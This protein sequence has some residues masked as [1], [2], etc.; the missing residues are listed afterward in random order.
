MIFISKNR[1]RGLRST[2]DSTNGQPESLRIRTPG[3]A[4]ATGRHG[5]PIASVNSTPAA[6]IVATLLSP[7]AAWLTESDALTGPVLVDELDASVFDRSADF[8]ACALAATELAFSGFQS[9]DRGF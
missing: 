6:V 7:C 3:C 8:L 2:S 1:N 4:V 9:G 5:P